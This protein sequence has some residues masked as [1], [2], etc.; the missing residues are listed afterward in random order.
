MG[1][2]VIRQVKYFGDSYYYESPRLD[3]GLTIIKG[4]NGTGKTTFISLIYYCLGGTIS[5]FIKTGTK[6]NTS[7]G[8][9]TEI[10]GDTNNFVELEIEINQESYFIKRF[11]QQNDIYVKE[12]DK[13]IELLPVNRNKNNPYTFS[14]WLLKKLDIEV[15]EL[16]QSSQNY[17]LNMTDLFRLIYHNQEASPNRVFK[18]PDHENYI[19]DS[20]QLRK[21]I[22]QILVGKTFMDYYSALAEQRRLEKERSV[23]KSVLDEYS[24]IANRLQE[25]KDG[26][27]LIFLEEKK[28]ELEANLDR[29]IRAREALKSNRPTDGSDKL[30]RLDKLKYTFAGHESQITYLHSELNQLLNEKVKL[31]QHREDLVLEVTQIK[32]I[33]HT[34][35]TL[36]LFSIDTCPYCLRE[37]ERAKGHCVCGQEIDEEEYEKFF[38]NSSEYTDI[39]KSKQKSVTTIDVAIKS[40]IDES[41]EVKK[42]IHSEREKSSSVRS[43][44]SGLI[45]E[46]DT[47]VDVNKLNEVDDKILASRNTIQILNQQLEIERARLEH[48]KKYDSLNA[49]YERQKN[50]TDA[51][52]AEANDEILNKVQQFNEIYNNLMINTLQEC[53]SA[54]IDFQ[55]YLPVINNG[56]YREASSGVT[57]RLNYYLTLLSMALRF[58][59]VKFPKLLL[60]DT[61]RTAGI[62]EKNIKK[63]LKQIN[64]I[65]PEDNK[66]EYQVI[67]TT[68]PDTYPSEFEGNIILAL[69][70]EDKLLQ[71]IN[72]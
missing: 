54:R 35:E 25:Y 5:Q 17:R 23:A 56:E 13:D 22:F 1:Y 45:L 27:N 32:K 20:E 28:N 8:K 10:T 40:V 43:D 44:I 29:L 46:L 34:H 51:L 15:V 59:D 21:T 3:N 72:K 19:T 60:I 37:V 26:L 42:D 69:K 68:G 4:P 71:K 47:G 41:N 24:I 52:K 49:A 16:F 9:H 50:K 36:S 39:L 12:P 57:I 61:P 67:L 11:F 38:Y 63:A 58:D 33:I 18:N 2:L 7:R 53:R 55:T 62:D 6:A 31:E 64:D 65:V 14:D 70:D 66:Q 48:Q 30:S